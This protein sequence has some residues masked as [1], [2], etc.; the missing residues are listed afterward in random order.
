MSELLGSWTTAL[1]DEVADVLDSLREPVNNGERI[2][3]LERSR[4]RPT[5]PYYGATGQAGLID[6]YIFDDNLILLGEDGVPFLEVGKR[7]AYRVSGKC[8]VNNHAHVLRARSEVADWRLVCY[9]LNC[10]DYQVLV[11]GSTRLKLTQEAMRRI[12]LPLPPLA[13]QKRIA[14]KLDAILA[15]VDAC[16]DRLDRVVPLLQRFKQSV[17][18]S[19]TTGALTERWRQCHSAPAWQ[20]M[21]IGGIGTVSGGL[22]KNEKRDALKT[23]YRYLRVAN[24]HANRLDLADVADIGA[25]QAEFQKTRLEDGDLLIVEGNGS[26]DQVGRVAMWRNEQSDCCHQNH[27]IRWRAGPDALPSFLLFWLMS[28]EGRAALMARA[29]SSSGL[30]T[31]S[32]SKVSGIELSL[33]SLAEQAAIVSEVNRLFVLADRIGERLSSARAT[34]HRMTPAVLAKAFRGEL[35]PQDPADEPAQALLDRLRAQHLSGAP[36]PRRARRTSPA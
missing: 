22:T 11:T 17:L 13:E 2:E 8:W 6:D 27:L 18:H 31:L 19:A 4:G 23:R 25:T 1:I 34:A 20:R 35:V 26:I 10:H 14:D 24:V 33:P 36:P 9:A 30:H 29:S 16:R 32:I 15:R 28:P 7:K 12:R 3:R 5:Y 21:L